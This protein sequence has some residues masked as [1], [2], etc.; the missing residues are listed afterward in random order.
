RQY[1]DIDNHERL[2]NRQQAACFAYIS[3]NNRKLTPCRKR[4]TDIKRCFR[5]SACKPRGK[6][7]RGY[8]TND[9][10]HRGQ[11]SPAHSTSQRIH[12]NGQP[13]TKKE[14]CAEK[15]TIWSNNTFY[16]PQV[17]RICKN[18]P[19]HQRTDRLGNMYRFGKP[20]NQKQQTK[21]DQNK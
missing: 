16:L 14:H 10:N 1:K 21:Y 13:K 17:T 4:E 20:S 6:I 18:Q 11:C 3:H 5:L 15:I 2:E 7:P 12:I 19:R 8:V 9:G